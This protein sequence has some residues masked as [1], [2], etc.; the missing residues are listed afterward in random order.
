MIS[1]L[2]AWHSGDVER[3]IIDKSLTPRLHGTEHTIRSSKSMVSKLS[4]QIC[5]IIQCIDGANLVFGHFNNVYSIHIFN[6]KH[7]ENLNLACS[8][9][10]KVS[11]TIL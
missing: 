6:L 10:I 7:I 1:F 3:I 11:I 8:K 4:D 9:L 2:V 5:S